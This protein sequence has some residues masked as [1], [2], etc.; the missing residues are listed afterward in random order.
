MYCILAVKSEGHESVKQSFTFL[1]AKI[2]NL[3]QIL[4]IDLTHS[5]GTHLCPY[6]LRIIYGVSW[7]IGLN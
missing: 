7:K 4:L 1:V 5:Q 2:Q 3:L 6:T